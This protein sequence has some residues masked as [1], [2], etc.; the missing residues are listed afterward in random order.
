MKKSYLISLLLAA[1]ALA[2]IAIGSQSRSGESMKVA[3]LPRVTH[4]HGIAVDREDPSRLYIATHH[5]LFVASADDGTA[6]RVSDSRDDFMGFT[7]HPSDPS[8]LYA[9]G[10]PAGGGNL[11]FIASTDGGRTW[12][13]LAEGVGGPVD[14]HQMDVSK[15]DPS[16]VYGVYGGLQVSRDG[17]RTWQ[18][19][20]LTPD[21]LIDLAASAGDVDTLY[22]AT[23][24]GLL[25]SED[26]GQSWRDAFLLRRPVT[27][28]E[29]TPD[30]GVYAFVV[31]AGLMRAT[32]PDL[33]WTPLGDGGF[34][35]GYVLHLAVDPTD[36]QK[37]YAVTHEGDVLA[38]RDGGQT[39]AAF[40]SG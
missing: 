7:P 31:G 38:S 29:T 5:G 9:S 36:G 8:M 3:E 23:E 35:D 10:H 25:I 1:V 32:E 14:F 26:G 17:G 28:V 13:R 2:G 6:A 21:R 4:I 11:G 40:G 34:G 15:A 22:A 24:A 12:S 39:W 16:T 18:M 30:G 20:G 37:L 19:V 27:M 33:D